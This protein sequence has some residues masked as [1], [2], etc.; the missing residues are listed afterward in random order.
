MSSKSF[1]ISLFTL[2]K[3]GS[4]LVGFCETSDWIQI[5]LVE[6]NKTE[7]CMGKLS[8]NP[9]LDELFHGH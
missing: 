8:F 4:N 7:Y 3:A 9:I 2:F 1:L 6:F 5:F